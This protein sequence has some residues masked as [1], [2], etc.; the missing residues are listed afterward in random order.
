MSIYRCNSCGY[1]AEMA[2]DLAGRDLQCPK[3][4][5]VNSAYDTLL[6]VR[7]VLEKYFD[8]RAT[9]KELRAQLDALDTSETSD[10]ESARQGGASESSSPDRRDDLSLEGIDLHN[11]SLLST[12]DLHRPI[13]DWLASKNIAL[14]AAPKAIDTS[15]FFDEAAIL[16]GSNLE[17]YKPVL[18]QI[19]YAQTRG[20]N[21][22]N[23]ALD[24]RSQKDAQALAAFC[25]QLYDHSFL[26]KCFHQ[27][28][29]RNL[30]LTLQPSPQIRDFLSGGWLEWYALMQILGLCQERRLSFACARNLG[31][32]FPNEDLHELDLFWLLDRSTPVCIECKSGE[33]RQLI[34]KYSGLRK[35][36]ALE[37]EQFVLCVAGLPE[38][39]AS[40][41]TSMYD[42]TLVSE[43]GLKAHL[44]TL[45]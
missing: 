4:G 23:I 22:L 32:V 3:C 27:K 11:T 37:K 7:K 36:L 12:E 28:V 21:Q 34:G 42:I 10:P 25:R 16:I 41:L 29:E 35:R 19:R 24:K 9:N 44:A 5:R 26:A 1:L 33:F 15:G 30:R 17:L 6:F 45:V 20:F 39:Q 38:D 2:S 40:G 43:R 18:D 14:N 31:V 8:L 13:A